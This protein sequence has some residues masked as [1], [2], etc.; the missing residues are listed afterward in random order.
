LH[1]QEMSI[2]ITHSTQDLEKLQNQLES[3]KEEVRNL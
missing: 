1:L 2:Q 3:I